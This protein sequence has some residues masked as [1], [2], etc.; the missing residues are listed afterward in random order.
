MQHTGLLAGEAVADAEILTTVMK[1]ATRRV[2]PGRRPRKGK[3]SK[4][5]ELAGY[6][7]G[8]G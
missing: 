2:R 1:D 8:S 6:D 3:K 4:R 7:G 5:I